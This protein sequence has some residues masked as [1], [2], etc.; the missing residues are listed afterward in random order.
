MA[1]N[2]LHVDVTWSAEDAAAYARV[3]LARQMAG[4]GSSQRVYTSAVAAIGGVVMGAVVLGLTRSPIWALLA[5]LIGV[6]FVVAA[7]WAQYLDGNTRNFVRLQRADPA[8][9]P[10]RRI[11]LS[12]AGIVERQEGFLA[13]LSWHRVTE[14]TRS[15]GIIFCWISR[16]DSSAVP[17]RCFFD[18]A[19][20]DAFHA[21]LLARSRAARAT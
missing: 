11:E 2:G 13:E 7:Q 9:Y 21:E 6:A 16:S 15:D 12:E 4:L 18:K 14:V 5:T 3:T 17:E 1:D 20:A 10:A 8:S 19:A